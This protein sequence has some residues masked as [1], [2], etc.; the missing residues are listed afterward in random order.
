MT[1]RLLLCAALLAACAHRPEPRRLG[2]WAASDPSWP[3]RDQQPRV[4]Y[5]GELRMPENLG[6]ERSRWSRFWAIFAGDPESDEMVRPVAVAAA[7]DGRIAVS[8]SG[9]RAVHVYDPVRGEYHRIFGHLAAPAGVAFAPDGTLWVSDP[10]ARRVYGHDRQGNV[11]RVLQDYARPT[12]LAISGDGKSL[13]VVD[14]GSHAVVAEPL[15]GGER[16]Y[17]GGRGGAAG[18]MNYPTWIAVGRAGE[19][20]VCDALNFRIQQF[21]ARGAFLRAV[22]QLGDGPG[23]LSRPKGI[24]LDGRGDLYVIEA[25]ADVVQVFEPGGALA[26]IFGGRGVTEGKFWLPQGAAV[27]G[28]DRLFVAD[29]YNHRVQVFELL[30]GPGA[31][32]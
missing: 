21:D 23:D 9:R 7:A 12:G 11:T 25:D 14:T 24:G 31:K 13:L 30:P 3:E 16:W 4:R 20:Y 8:D 26:L 6:I 10:E 27:D 22:G 32:P 17:F 18:K 28:S 2:T 29:A 5:V 19:I 15:V 1:G